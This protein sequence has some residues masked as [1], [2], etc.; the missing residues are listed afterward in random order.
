MA[1]FQPPPIQGQQVVSESG[2]FTDPV[3][4]WLELIATFLSNAP[5]LVSVPATSTSP[6]SPNQMASDGNFLYFCT[7]AN[8]WK[9]IAL[10]GF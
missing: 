3:Q 5:L 6:G 8:Q 9:R 1:K 2:G 10:S 4:K 7:G